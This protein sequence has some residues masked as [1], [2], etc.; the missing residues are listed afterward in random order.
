VE[1]LI[2]NTISCQE[3]SGASSF[4]CLFSNNSIQNNVSLSDKSLISAVEIALS[5]YQKKS[6]ET[7][8]LNVKRL[9]SLAPSIGHVGFLT[10]T[11]K[12]NI[13][14][15]KVAYDR[16]RSFNSNF[17]ALSPDFGHWICVKEPQK[18]G[19]WHFHLLV[20]LAQDILT[21]FDFQA[22]SQGDYRSA[23]PYLRQLWSILRRSLPKYG[24]GRSELLPIKSNGEGIGRYIGKYI[25]KGIKGRSG[26][27]KGV[28]LVTYSKGW[29]RHSVKFQWNTKGSA[30]WRRKVKLFAWENRCADLHEL[31]EKFGPTWAYSRQSVIQDIDE[32]LQRLNKNVPF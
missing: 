28:R 18:R 9:V 30:E 31:K 20:I 3:S 11:F 24:F 10:L 4:P 19:A 32:L 23:S 5:A 26:D 12:D 7:L 1:I 25:S 8:Y 21:G 16:F 14:D 22:I 17:L 15:S 29:S 6:A 13:T 27:Q 2:A